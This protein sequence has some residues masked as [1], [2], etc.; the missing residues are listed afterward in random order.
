MAAAR[1]P[2]A[3][4]LRA[5]LAIAAPLAAANIAQMLMGLT[6]TIMVGHLGGG[7]L[8]A[9]GL[10]GSL[11]FSFVIVCRSVL[12]AVAPLAAHAV[13]AGDPREAGLLAGTGL[14]LA[15]IAAAPIIAMLKAV[16][17]LLVAIGYAPGL[18]AAIGEYLAAVSWA[19]PAF[20]AFEVLRALLAATARARAVLIAAALAVPA[21]ALLCWSLIFGHLGMPALGITGAGYATATIQWLMGLGL[22]ALIVLAP[23]RTSLRVS[24]HIAARVRSILRLGLPIGGL[25]ALEVGLFAA[26]GVLMGLFGPDALAAHNLA[27]N[28]ASLTFMVPL[29]IGQ[30]ATVRIAFELGA[31]APPA[32]RRAGMVALGIGVAVMTAAAVIIWAARGGIAGLYLDLAD[33]ANTATAAIAFELLAVAAVF[34]VFDG[35]QVIAA[36]ALRGYRDAVVPMLIAA[37]GYWGVGFAGGW[38]LAFPLARG[39]FGLWLGLAAGL[40]VVATLLTLRLLVLSRTAARTGSARL[41]PV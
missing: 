23:R 10:G 5:L 9:A 3:A 28:V 30:S 7:A 35:I 15:V 2:L 11:Y 34:Q 16:S 14:V 29:G 20:L 22:T 36:G 25:I 37:F 39:A 13:G 41:A 24:R 38:A 8:A 19:V 26:A 1:H 17:P 40:A 18:A 31:A 12:A 27:L 6:N 33:P 32:A 4:E 21:N